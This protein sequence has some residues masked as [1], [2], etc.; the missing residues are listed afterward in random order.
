VTWP[1]AGIVQATLNDGMVAVG[2]VLVTVGAESA[3][4]YCG[5]A[6]PLLGVGVNCVMLPVA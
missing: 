5:F 2:L 4:K 1:L 3:E 6:K